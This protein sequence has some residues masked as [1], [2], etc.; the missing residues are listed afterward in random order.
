MLLGK[1]QARGDSSILREEFADEFGAVALSAAVQ[2][3]D[4]AWNL[5]SV[6]FAAI[7]YRLDGGETLRV[8]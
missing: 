7:E 5:Q 1:D 3:H 6:F 8:G 4:V 2:Q